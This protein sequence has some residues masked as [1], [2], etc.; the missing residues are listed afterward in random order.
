M[1]RMFSTTSSRFL[2]LLGVISALVYAL[3]LDSAVEILLATGILTS[4]PD[5][6]IPYLIALVPLSLFYVAALKIVPRESGKGLVLGVLFFA[7]LFR[8]AL[9]FEDPVRSSDMY[10]YLWDGRVQVVGELN[11]YLY[12]PEDANL[13]ALRD[14]EIYPHINRKSSPT[15]YP[16]GA[17]LLFRFL[18]SVGIDSPAKFKAT[19]LLADGITIAI[20]LLIL[21]ELGR[22]LTR[23]LIYAWNPLVVHEIFHSGHLDAFML[24]L[25]MAFVYL[26]LRGWL[27]AAGGFLGLAAA[28][29]LVPVLLLFVVPLAKLPKLLLPFFLVILGAYLPYA[30]AG[31][32]VLG[33]LPTYFSDPYE[34]FNPGLLQLALFDAAEGFFSFPFLWAR[35]V[36][37]F[38]FGVFLLWGLRRL[39]EARPEALIERAC[40][41][42]G[43]HLLFI[44]PAFHPWYLLSLMPFLAL[45]PA[46][47]WIY[48]SLAIPLSYLK[49]L[50]PDGLMPGWVTWAQFAPLYVLL[51][52]QYARI[53]ALDEWRY[54]WQPG[55]QRTSSITS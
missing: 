11:P 16:A 18:Y 38:A 20:L 25:A 14:E 37:L 12:P 40:V 44:Y 48:L 7:F 54:P 5:S 22:P 33:F 2:W 28:I 50:A 41:V 51:G 1:R 29:K 39:A 34:I 55:S 32:K 30:A 23:I 52:L 4:R 35:Y 24:P 8:L 21:S 47:A 31:K 13:T 10:R 3:N 53:K 26:V 15:I 45:S 46:P 17:Q 36:L 9:V 49:Y 27:T 6:V 43:A 19:A 42:L